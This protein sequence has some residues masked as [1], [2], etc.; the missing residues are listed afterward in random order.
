MGLEKLKEWA[1]SLSETENVKEI[2]MNGDYKVIAR[3]YSKI[4][5]LTAE[6]YGEYKL[7]IMK[8]DGS[9]LNTLIYLSSFDDVNYISYLKKVN[10]IAFIGEVDTEENTIYDQEVYLGIKS[11]EPTLF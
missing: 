4:V 10:K 3:F 8:E 11:K 1:G 6:Y 7:R 9:E 2:V 5:F